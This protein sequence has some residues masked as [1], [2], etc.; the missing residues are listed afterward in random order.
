MTAGFR[1]LD[2]IHLMNAYYSR[3]DVFLTNDQED[4]LRR[5]SALY[6]RFALEV[7]QPSELLDRIDTARIIRLAADG[8]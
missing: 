2:V 6:A 3:C 7:L 8:G 4:F 5:G 1:K